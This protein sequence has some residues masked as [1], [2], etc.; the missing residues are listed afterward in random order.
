MFSGEEIVAWME[1]VGISHCVWLPDSELGRWESALRAARTVRLVR[2]CRE[3][4]AM[5]VAGGLWLAGCQPIVVIQSTGFFDSGDAFRNMVY[6]LGIP[7]FLIVGYR[8]Y[9]SKTDGSF[10][11]SAARFLEPILRA[12][13]IAY[14]VMAPRTP[15]E[16]LTDFYREAQASGQA[17]VALLAEGQP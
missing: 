13:E 17:A 15:L 6:D 16:L 2:V 12:W 9:F 4:E 1:R 14:V 3:A 7:L 5:A 11:D 10:S 8:G